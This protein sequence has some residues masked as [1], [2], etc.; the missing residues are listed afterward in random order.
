MNQTNQTKPCYIKA[1]EKT[2]RTNITVSTNQL[3]LTVRP[4]PGVLPLFYC[5]LPHSKAATPTPNFILV[6][7]CTPAGFILYPGQ[8]S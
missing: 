6:I 4:S 1:P 7:L 5:P 2:N 3:A 8:F